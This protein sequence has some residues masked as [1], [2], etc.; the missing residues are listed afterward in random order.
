MKYDVMS[1]VE[2]PT[3]ELPTCD[4]C[5]RLRVPEHQTRNYAA[6]QAAHPKC[7]SCHIF[8]GGTHSGGAVAAAVNGYCAYCDCCQRKRQRIG[9]EIANAR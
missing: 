8:F 1:D 5:I 9:E 7:R 6:L 4:V 3:V 2:L